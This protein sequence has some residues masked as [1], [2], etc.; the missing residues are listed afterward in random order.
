MRADS[1]GLKENKHLLGV[2]F[3]GCFF[4]SVITFPLCCIIFHVAN[5]TIIPYYMVCF[6]ERVS[7]NYYLLAAAVLSFLWAGVHLFTGGKYIAR[8]LLGP[9][10]KLYD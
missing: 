8:P 2:E 10:D 9:V 7:M 3:N 5:F 4:I 1:F 6:I